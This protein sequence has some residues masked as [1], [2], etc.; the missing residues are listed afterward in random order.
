MA[1]F[2]FVVDVLLKDYCIITNQLLVSAM[3]SRLLH[4]LPCPSFTWQCRKS[5]LS[6]TGWMTQLTLFINIQDL[7]G[8]FQSVWMHLILSH[9]SL[10]WCCLNM[11][12]RP[13]LVGLVGHG[14]GL[15][16]PPR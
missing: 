12:G 15:Q 8:K 3:Y 16:L 6:D 4:I 14:D 10:S 9:H 2:D 1:G 11:A 5:L 7:R 13:R